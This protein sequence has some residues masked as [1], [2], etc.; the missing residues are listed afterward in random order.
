MYTIS[1][2][3]FCSFLVPCTYANRCREQVFCFSSYHVFCFSS[4]N[5]FF[6]LMI[7]IK[8]TFFFYIFILTFGIT[9]K[10]LSIFLLA[11]IFLIHDSAT[12]LLLVMQQCCRLVV[13]I[14][15][16]TQCCPDNHSRGNMPC[17]TVKSKSSQMRAM[18]LP[19]L[20]V[21]FPKVKS[22]VSELS[23]TA[24]ASYPAS[25]VDGNQGLFSNRLL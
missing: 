4:F 14:H 3:H 8:L 11:V 23:C 24:F 6:L 16:S 18:T 22:T 13:Q 15:N 21:K 20:N 19:Q 1:D 7:I 10:Y 2:N 12:D 9:F 17:F 5:I 25:L